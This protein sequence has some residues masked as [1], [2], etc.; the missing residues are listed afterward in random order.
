VIGRIAELLRGQALMIDNK[1]Q[2]GVEIVAST[3]AA[4]MRDIIAIVCDVTGVTYGE[5]VSARRQRRLARPRQLCCWLAKNF[6]GIS[7]PVM[8][9]SL[10][11]RDHTTSMHAVK[12]IDSIRGEDALIAGWITEC[13]ARMREM[14]MIPAE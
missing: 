2:T 6:T 11:G 10:G 9:R 5:I 8:A 1:A 3:R 13:E 7:Y 14:N 4:T 12:K